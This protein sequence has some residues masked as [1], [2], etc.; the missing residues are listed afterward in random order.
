MGFSSQEYWSGLLCPPPGNLPD[1]GIKATSLTSPA[2]VGGFF[3]TGAAW[4]TPLKSRVLFKFSKKLLIPP[5]KKQHFS[6][7]PSGLRLGSVL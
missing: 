7:S 2:L 1:P 4:E 3:T 6:T 5:R